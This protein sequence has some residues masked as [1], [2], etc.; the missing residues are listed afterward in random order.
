MTLA[1]SFQFHFT[2]TCQYSLLIPLPAPTAG[3]KHKAEDSGADDRDSQAK[4]QRIITPVAM[5]DG[6]LPLKKTWEM[7]EL[8]N[9]KGLLAKFQVSPIRCLGAQ[10]L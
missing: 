8:N 9:R 2:Y 7:T 3:S 1:V 4:K 5:A 6:N 10:F